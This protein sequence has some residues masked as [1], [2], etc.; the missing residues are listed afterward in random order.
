MIPALLILKS[1]ENDDKEICAIFY[2]DMDDAQ[3]DKGKEVLQLR[4]VYSGLR[5]KLGSYELYNLM[6]KL[7]IEAK[8][9]ENDQKLFKE[10]DLE[11]TLLKHIRGL[12]LQLSRFRPADWNKFLDVVI[13]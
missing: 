11:N 13:R 12:A 9:E 5:K 10:L 1:I 4:A 3:S 7:L 8:L 6:E 2:P